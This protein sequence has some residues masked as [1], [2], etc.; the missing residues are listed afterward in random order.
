M[1]AMGPNV[2]GVIGTVLAAGIFLTL[3]GRLIS[4][5]HSYLTPISRDAD[6]LKAQF[7]PFVLGSRKAP[8]SFTLHLPNSLWLCEEVLKHVPHRQLSLSGAAEQAMG[9]WSMH[10]GHS[11]HQPGERE[12]SWVLVEF[13]C[14]MEWH[15]FAFFC[16]R[17]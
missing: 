4:C 16:S 10:W 15:L 3:I 6:R 12:E 8:L 1:H 11:L 14:C 2:A 9:K 5:P 7:R 17:D 13:A